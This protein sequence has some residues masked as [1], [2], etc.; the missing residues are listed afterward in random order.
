MTVYTRLD[1]G[2]TT[3]DTQDKMEVISSI[4]TNNASSSFTA[5][6]P[7]ENGI[8]NDTFTL[9][10]EV[11]ISADTAIRNE[12]DFISKWSLDASNAVP[13]GM[14]SDGI[15]IW[16]ANSGGMGAY[17]VHKYDMD[18]NHISNWSLHVASLN[19]RGITNDGTF[20]WVSD[21]GTESVYKYDMDGNYVS[22][23]NL[24]A[25]ND[26][27]T[28]MTNNGTNIW[29]VDTDKAV[30]K[31]DM[32]GN[33]I[34]SW[35]LDD[36][37]DFPRGMTTD[38]TN[39]WITDTQDDETYKYDMDG[40]YISKWSLNVDNP[41]P[42]GI[43]NNGT[44][45]WVN[46]FTGSDDV[47]KYYLSSDTRIFTGT[48]EDIK[49]KGKGTTETV[50]L[51]G[52]DYTARLMDST[53]EPE[54]YN[55]TEVSVIVRD[56]IDKYVDDIT[57]NN[58]NGTS[59]T[60]TNITF[61][62]VPV[63][64]ALQQ[65]AEQAKFYFYIDTNKDLHFEEKDKTSSGKT[66]NNTNVTK[67]DFKET[68]RELFNK[69]WVY[70][71]RVLTGIHEDFTTLGPVTTGSAFD[72][73]YRPHNTQVAVNGSVY[74][75]GVFEMTVGTP[76]SGTQYLVDFDGK[77]VVFVSGTFAGDNIPDSGND[78]DLDY[79][80]STPIIKYGQNN[81]SIAQY[82]PH[83]KVIQ[84]T[85]IIDP[86]M[87]RDVL[88]NVLDNF[89][90]PLTQG[91]FWL[92]DVIN[93]IPGNTVIVDMPHQNINNETFTVLQSRYT[94]NK[95]TILSNQVLE[96]KVSK[97]IKDFL[98]TIKELMLAIRKMQ[99]DSIETADVISRLEFATGS[100]GMRIKEWEV[101]GNIATGSVGH[102]YGTG[103]IPATTPFH[104]A[105]GTDQ[106]VLAGAPLGS[107]FG[108]L[109]ILRS[110]GEA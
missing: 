82:G 106:Q 14:T 49:F 11:V 104:L 9:N 1:V 60:L 35:N 41:F 92:H 2:G 16:V 62:Q 23:W 21:R 110:G 36:D 19:P 29:V 22:T 47:F 4:G 54:V 96:V 37:N 81:S 32:D 42:W 78:I 90:E 39:I 85:S 86:N 58:V 89:S 65:L 79:D 61:N 91:K 97:K 63:Y 66:L 44:N 51:K 20:I 83:T 27:T 59:T 25:G 101:R 71:D 95:N 7:N 94:F 30:Y 67:S 46:N 103:F 56:I 6:F 26:D 48:I 73:A 34:S 31:Y 55:N 15:N 98:D 107:A 69:V 105:S 8:H 72:L 12:G 28:G 99:A 68:D 3:Y 45:F 109:V 24:V 5:T 18:G 10:D 100:F 93:L 64:D 17:T 52:R 53:V 76:L 70:G 88:V 77:K 57:T 102:L 50:Q 87:A 40:N 13:R 80:R 43:T 33:Y 38:G 74:Q 108:P 84:D 75:G